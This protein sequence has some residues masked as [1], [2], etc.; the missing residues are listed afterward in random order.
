MRF[1]A[2]GEGAS[3]IRLDQGTLIEEAVG[4]DAI[5][6]RGEVSLAKHAEVFGGYG[7]G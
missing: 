6:P 5:E 1:R 4:H 7:L 2:H 3:L